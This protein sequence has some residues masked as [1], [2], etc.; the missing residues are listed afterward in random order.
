MLDKKSFKKRSSEWLKL[1]EAER[2]SIG[3]KNE[4]DGEFW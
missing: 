1:S 2:K 3:F 4:K